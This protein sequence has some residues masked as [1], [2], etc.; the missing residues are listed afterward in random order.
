MDFV[1]VLC[2]NIFF[3]RLRCRTNCYRDQTLRSRRTLR[4]VSKVRVHV[5]DLFPVGWHTHGDSCVPCARVFGF[6]HFQEQ[7]DWHT[8]RGVVDVLKIYDH[9][10]PPGYGAVTTAANNEPR[11]LGTADARKASRRSGRLNFPWQT[12]LRPK[13]QRVIV[14]IG[15]SEPVIVYRKIN[16]EIRDGSNR[17]PVWHP[18]V[19]TKR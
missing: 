10:P 14:S 7:N 13:R 8:L 2:E 5:E 3:K 18:C 19:L 12:K 4:T 11:F 15:G 6:R 17:R 16:F 9:L 1:P